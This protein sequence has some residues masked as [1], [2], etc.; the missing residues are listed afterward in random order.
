MSDIDA[1]IDALMDDYNAM[2]PEAQARIRAAFAKPEIQEKAQR[3]LDLMAQGE[4]LLAEWE[5][6]EPDD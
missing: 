2:S 4:A 3:L 6:D 5:E 1:Q